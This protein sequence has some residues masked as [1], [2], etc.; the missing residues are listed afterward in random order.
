[1]RYTNVSRTELGAKLNAADSHLNP[2]KLVVAYSR[3]FEC[4]PP[5]WQSRRKIACTEFIE[6]YRQPF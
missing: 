1:M 4:F 2:Q 6:V 3:Q 5:E